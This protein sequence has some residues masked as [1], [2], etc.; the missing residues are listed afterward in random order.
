[1]QH[2]REMSPKHPYVLQQL[3]KL[4]SEMN[5]WQGV[6]DVLPDLKK[7]HVLPSSDVKSLSTDATVGQLESAIARHDWNKVS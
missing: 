4:Y 2:L 7:R 5:E 3:Q 6:Q 1:M